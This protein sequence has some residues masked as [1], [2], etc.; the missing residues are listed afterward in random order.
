MDGNISMINE[1]VSSTPTLT[2]Y[3]VYMYSI[4]VLHLC[5]V[6]LYLGPYTYAVPTTL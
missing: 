1:S 4:L 2:P 5:N 6:L 3:A